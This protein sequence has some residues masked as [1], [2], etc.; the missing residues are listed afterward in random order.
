M[1]NTAVY[2]NV[3]LSNISAV[4]IGSHF[5]T[6]LLWSEAAKLPSQFS[7]CKNAY[8]KQSKCFE[9]PEISD[10]AERHKTVHITLTQV[11]FKE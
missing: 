7:K 8:I 10:S 1:Q 3:V 9:S 2:V 5:I 11:N 4:R 6:F